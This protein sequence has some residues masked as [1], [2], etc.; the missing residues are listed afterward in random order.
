MLPTDN[1]RHLHDRLRSGVALISRLE[2]LLH[3]RGDPEEKLVA[4]ARVSGY[5]QDVVLPHL[6]AEQAALYP[7]AARVPEIDV[8]L[9]RHLTD[10]CEELE[11]QAAR[12]LHDHARLRGRVHDN[13][14]CR[15]H[16][17]ALVRLLRRH[18]RAVEDELLP[19]LDGKLADRDL[20]RIYERVEE[21]SFEEI[22]GAGEHPAAAMESRR[23]PFVSP[24]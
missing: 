23:R 16:L 5:L 8:R 7:E 2:E 22:T 9:L 14:G 1:L 15:R 17:I 11:R 21:V 3:E 19:C 12:V 24:S 20:Y 10:N 4:F 6:R 18:L 13:V